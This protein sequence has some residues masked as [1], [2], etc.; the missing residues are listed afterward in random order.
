MGDEFVFLQGS[1]WHF[2]LS[3]RGGVCACVKR[4]N[5]TAGRNQRIGK[6]GYLI[7]TAKNIRSV[8]RC[9][10]M[11]EHYQDWASHE[12]GESMNLM[13][14]LVAD[15]GY[16]LRGRLPTLITSLVK[17]P[18]QLKLEIEEH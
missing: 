12:R 11:C 15:V 7:K 5:L 6:Y 9:E 1:E 8:N 10:Q 4:Y 17:E 16:L 14:S 18:D 3:V 2:V 13:G